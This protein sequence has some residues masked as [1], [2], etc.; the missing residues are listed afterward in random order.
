M[1]CGIEVKNMA[2]TEAVGTPRQTGHPRRWPALAVLLLCVV[3]MSLDN[4]I[5]NV[6]LK[7]I[8][9]DLGGTQSQME[10][11]INAYSLVF[12][13]L[14]VSFGV[15]GDRYGRK[16]IMLAGLVVF[17]GASVA[18][19]FVD[20]PGALIAAR[21]V[22]GVGAAA[23]PALSL[24][25]ISNLFPP[26]ERGRAIGIWSAAMGLGVGIGP[27]AGGF[28]LEHW[29]WGSIFLVNVPIVVLAAAGTVAIVPDSR[30]PAPGRL[31]P[32]GV[33]L[34]T[35]GLLALVYGIIRAGDRADWLRPDVLGT[36]GG[37]LLLL[38]AFAVYEWRS[39]HPAIDVRLFRHGAFAAAGAAL[40]LV[41]FALMG[42]MFFLTY[43]FQAVRG[44][45]PL[46]A[47]LLLLPAALGIM[48]TSPVSAPLARRL[49]A[50]AVTVTGLLVTAAGFAAFDRVGR[51]TATWQ[52]EGVVLVVGMA[53]GLTM[54]PATD[55][56]MARVPP[57]R[58]GA[59][60]AI[61]STVRQVGGALGVA[62]LG[63]VLGTGYRS[64]LGGATHLLPAGRRSGA[65]DSIASTLS[66]VQRAAEAA[67]HGAVPADGLRSD[68]LSLADTARDAYVAAMHTTTL[69]AAA[70]AVL[71]AVVCA[72][73]VPGRRS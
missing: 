48:A 15:L 50:K 19:A 53:I 59:G 40:L 65:G 33:A 54:A 41:F 69:W 56:L 29:W 21:A 28:L 58:S 52:Y 2:V 55:V 63:S 1:R 51:A 4:T 72:V 73:G 11:T 66:A 17:G 7:T 62:V 9:Q 49:G 6:A 61:N 46:R 30:D 64:H 32:V 31:D 20:S 37:G 14:L 39:D 36:I 35:L 23:I 18:A 27:V 43:Y 5:L 60:A 22:M 16:W 24:S 26:G 71:G 68:L 70:I 34:S 12:A 45:S 13:G 67:R 44:A 25:I 42:I 47:G 38:A 3:V 57:E 10:W 8:Q